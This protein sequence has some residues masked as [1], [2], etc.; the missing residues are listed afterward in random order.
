MLAKRV[1]TNS[2]I[3]VFFYPLPPPPP[4]QCSF[5]SRYGFNHLAPG[6]DLSYP[7]SYLQN[8]TLFPGEGAIVFIYGVIY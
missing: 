8:P 1:G 7:M 4:L 3:S 5:I 6:Y 2:T